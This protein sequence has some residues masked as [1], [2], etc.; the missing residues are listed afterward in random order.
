MEFFA[1]HGGLPS[2]R[3]HSSVLRPFNRKYR[4]SLAH[5]THDQVRN[6]MERLRKSTVRTCDLATFTV[7][8]RARMETL[9]SRIRFFCSTAHLRRTARHK[10]RSQSF[11][12]KEAE[13]ILNK[14]RAKSGTRHLSIVVGNPCFGTGQGWK[15]GG[16]P[17]RRLMYSL[18]K[19]VRRRSTTE[20]ISLIRVDEAWTTKR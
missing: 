2:G 10:L 3:Y 17:W 18:V 13:N 16:A 20:K 11:F 15:F 9:D 12:D 7:G 6:D 8:L 4:S 19:S 5:H 14:A 1:C